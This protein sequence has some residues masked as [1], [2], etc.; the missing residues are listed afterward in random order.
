MNKI[1][2]ISWYIILISA[3]LRLV[4]TLPYSNNGHFD[5][6][7]ENPEAP[8]LLNQLCSV[9]V[10]EDASD[11]SPDPDYD[12]TYGQRTSK[13]L[14]LCFITLSIGLAA[15]FIEKPRM[16]KVSCGILFAILAL[17]RVFFWAYLF[18]S[19]FWPADFM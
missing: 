13:F 9:M 14:L 12:N 6:F 16:L 15:S 5:Y 10:M 8:K 18:S 1:I 3:I 4:T 7:Q 11:T 17:G 19:G 2:K